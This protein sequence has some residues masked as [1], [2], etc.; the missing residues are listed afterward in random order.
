MK[1]KLS[2][3]G[4]K[5]IACLTMLLDHIGA[6]FV[7]GYYT[8]YTLRILGRVAF[9]IY[10]F[11]LTQG[12]RHTHDRRRYG[13]RLAVGMVASELPFD[14]AFYGGITLAHQSVMV[15]L[16][17]GF[18]ALVWGRNLPLLPRLMATTL[19][20]LLAE[21]LNTDYGGWGVA[22][23]VA[24]DLA[25]E[26]AHPLWT[27]TGMLAVISLLMGGA[28]VFGVP[29]ELFALLAMVPICLYS[30]QKRH[31]GRYFGF[32]SFYPV[33]LTALWLLSQWI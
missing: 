33:H 24:F 1:R 6:V 8:Y 17:L 4:L 3:E 9:P 19:T 5:T 23:I 16:L 18:V 32:Y 28:R 31:K 29:I 10:C 26:T 13:L 14:L 2:Q 30:G 7:P 22:L 11:L 21:W 20:A 25:Q 15:T 27:M 12:V